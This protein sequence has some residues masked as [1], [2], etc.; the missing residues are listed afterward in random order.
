[1]KC[2]PFLFLPFLSLLHMKLPLKSTGSLHLGKTSETEAVLGRPAKSHSNPARLR[3]HGISPFCWRSTGD[4]KWS[5]SEGFSILVRQK[6]VYYCS[7]GYVLKQ[8][9]ICFMPLKR[10]FYFQ[11][12]ESF[13]F[14]SSVQIEIPRLQ[15]FQHHDLSVEQEHTSSS[16]TLES[17]LTACWSPICHSRTLHLLRPRE[18]QFRRSSEIFP[19]WKHEERQDKGRNDYP[20]NFWNIVIPQFMAGHRALAGFLTTTCGRIICSP[21]CLEC[22]ASLTDLST[23]PLG[24]QL[25]LLFCKFGEPLRVWPRRLV[26]M[27]L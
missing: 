24:I 18:L 4:S 2:S 7:N 19:S 22:E 5:V 13:N 16:Y 27:G 8:S 20:S 1:M 11:V 12:S 25:V 3:S 23:W 10:L 14:S 26:G 17:R 15:T 6:T 21:Q 9:E